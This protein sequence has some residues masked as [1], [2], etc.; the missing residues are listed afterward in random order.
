VSLRNRRHFERMWGLW[1]RK[2]MPDEIPSNPLDDWVSIPR[3]AARP[4][5][6]VEFERGHVPEWWETYPNDVP[7]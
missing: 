4:L 7:K 3:G 2:T 5:P 6:I 1:G